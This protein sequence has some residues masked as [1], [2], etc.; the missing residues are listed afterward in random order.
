ME[1]FHP[2]S[3]GINSSMR[4]LKIRKMICLAYVLY[5]RAS[6]V[7]TFIRHRWFHF[8]YQFLL[9]YLLCEIHVENMNTVFSSWKPCWIQQYVLWPTDTKLEWAIICLFK[10]DNSG[11]LVEVP[12]VQ[13]GKSIYFPFS[14]FLRFIFYI[15][16]NRI[17]LFCV[18]LLK[19]NGREVWPFFGHSS[20]HIFI[21]LSLDC[22]GLLGLPLSHCFNYFYLHPLYC[23]WLLKKVG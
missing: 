19:H 6:E 10:A 23:D 11:L 4:K 3:A 2:S 1:I 13:K 20:P 15:R 22:L 9:Q 18:S 14:T 8:I 5:W 12:S 7:T 16:I 21:F 17:P